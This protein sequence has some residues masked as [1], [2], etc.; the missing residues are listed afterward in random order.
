MCHVFSN[1]RLPDLSQRRW[2]A[3]RRTTRLSQ[4]TLQY[5]A[6]VAAADSLNLLAMQQQFIHAGLIFAVWHVL[7]C[8]PMP[9]VLLPQA[10]GLRRPVTCV[11]RPQQ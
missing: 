9:V 3:C 7:L 4:R 1:L 8:R 6:A 11:L 2:V 10:S 5:A